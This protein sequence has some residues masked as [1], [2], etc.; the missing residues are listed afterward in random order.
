MKGKKQ[1]FRKKKLLA[2]VQLFF[3]LKKKEVCKL[4]GFRN[5]DVYV[6]VYTYVCMCIYAIYMYTYI[7]KYIHS[8]S[9]SD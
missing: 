3:A 7:D 8:V 2:F 6:C 4:V 5:T 1:S 9:V